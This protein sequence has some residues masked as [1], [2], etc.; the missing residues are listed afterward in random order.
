MADWG[1]PFHLPDFTDDEFEEARKEAVEKDGYKVKIPDL[2]DIIHLPAEEPMTE[3]EMRE[4]RK[5]GHGNIPPDRELELEKMKQKRRDKYDRMLRDPRPD[6]FRTKGSIMC[7]LDD[8]QD[9]LSTIGV[10]GRLLLPILP[11][12]AAALLGGP[13]G[14]TL[15]AAMLLNLM[16]QMGTLGIAS[17]EAKRRKNKL[18]EHNPFTK[19]GKAGIAKALRQ[20]GIRSGNLIEAAQVTDNI[21]GVG[22]CL[23]PLVALPATVASGLARSLIGQKVEWE[24]TPQDWEHWRK[25]AGRV[26]HSAPAIWGDEPFLTDQEQFE[27]IFAGHFAQQAFPITDEPAEAITNLINPQYLEVKAPNPWHI[28]SREVMQEADDD[29]D[30]FVGWPSTLTEWANINDLT[31]LT[32]PKAKDNIHGFYDNHAQDLIGYYAGCYAGEA[33]LYAMEN[34]GGR[35][36]VTTSFTTASRAVTGLLDLNYKLPENMTEKQL[37]CL[38]NCLEDEDSYDPDGAMTGVVQRTIETAWRECRIHIAQST[39]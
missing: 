28:L 15:T 7:A 29:P 38:A 12:A 22:L 39:D 17:R 23:G 6:I 21:W 10:L 35:G 37:E 20:K 33:G 30:E 27:V 14:W 1:A 26:L 5:P 25:A 18:S 36:S 24:V 9:C 16:R 2:E 4:W 11:R 8:V 31:D 34:A 13:I 32:Y 19:K 3:D